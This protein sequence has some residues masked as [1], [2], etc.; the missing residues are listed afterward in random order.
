MIPK[1]PV[2]LEETRISS[3]ITTTI[4]V[5]AIDIVVQSCQYLLSLQVINS[6][7][8]GRA[9]HLPQEIPSSCSTWAASPGPGHCAGPVSGVPSSA[10]L[11]QVSQSST[12]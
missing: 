7:R 5:I 3:K 11:P 10:L 8:K 12:S 6:G 4:I 9:L 2:Q 1:V